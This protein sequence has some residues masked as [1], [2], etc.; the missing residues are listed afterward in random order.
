MDNII[1]EQ[2]SKYFKE[3]DTRN[4][5]KKEGSIFKRSY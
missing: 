3:D 1:L 4:N 5:V 2:L